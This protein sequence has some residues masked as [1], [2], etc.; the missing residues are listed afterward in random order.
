MSEKVK[1]A[2]VP[3]KGAKL[4][5]QLVDKPIPKPFVYDESSGERGELLVKIKAIALNPIDVYQVES[6]L[7]VDGYP[8]I[9]GSDVSGV[10]EAVGEGVTEFSQGDEVCGYTK[11]GLPG[12][13]GA[14]SEY[15]LLEASTTFKKPPNLTFREAATIPVCSLT[16][17]L[18]LFESLKLPLPSENP[19]WFREEYILIWG[20]SSS[21]GSYAIQLAAHSGL[22]VIT[23][24]S[25]KNHQFL[26]QLGAAYT[27]DYNARDVVDQIKNASQGRLK[28]A[29]DTVGG[30]TTPLCIETLSKNGKLACVDRS[31]KTREDI[32]M[33][34][35][36]LGAAHRNPND[37]L[38]ST[39]RVLKEIE[40]MLFDG[41]IRPVNI[42]SMPGGL[43]GILPALEKLK[44][45]VNT[46]F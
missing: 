23:T 22:T 34:M 36:T 37:Y 10:V 41:R 25:P 44:S 7:M 35:V 27:F 18:G 15:T 1:A 43:D 39:N 20:G 21:V 16:A 30:K 31:A 46:N 32:E 11:L 26:Q 33:S 24:A 14:F 17:G 13:Y 40:I 19:G 12:H 45:G 2:V 6:G 28:Y 38:K 29:F 9:L 3:E 4:E 42:T 8:A 5:I